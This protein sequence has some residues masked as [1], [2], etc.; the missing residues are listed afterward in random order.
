MIS[1]NDTTE[2]KN[3]DKRKNIKA[4]MLIITYMIFG[5]LWLLVSNFLFP[6]LESKHYNM[7]IYRFLE[8]L[9]FLLITAF[10]LYFSVSK[11]ENYLY[12][13][14]N[15]LK[16]SNENLKKAKERLH[17]QIDEINYKE[18][19]LKV[20]EERYRLAT[21]GSKDG[22]WDLD[23]SN[24]ELYLS[25]RFQDLIGIKAN[26]TRRFFHK[27]K[28]YIHEDD[29]DFL[30]E[31]FQDYLEGT[32]ET[33]NVECRLKTK[34]DQYLW[35]SITG[36]GIWDED[37]NP[38][39]MAGSITDITE[40]KHSER[41]IYNLAYYDQITG[42]PSRSF[43]I[44]KLQELI[45]SSSKKEKNFVV[46]FIDLD[47]FKGVNDTLGHDLGDLLMRNLSGHLQE[48]FQGSLCSRFGGDEFIVVKEI[49]TDKDNISEISKNTVNAL[50]KDWKI[51]DH[52]FY[53]S[54]S[55][56]VS[57][58]PIH[59]TTPQ[60]LIKNADLAMYTAKSRG[61]NTYAIYNP[62]MRNDLL[63][64][65]Q[66]EKDI[67]KALDQDDFIIHY[68]PQV[69]VGKGSCIG[70]EALIRWVH[71]EKGNISPIEFIPIAEESGLIVKMGEIII[72][73]AVKQLRYW[74]DNNQKVV[75]VS[76]NLS[77]MQFQQQNLIQYIEEV[78]GKYSI[79]PSLIKLEI[80][81]STALKDINQTINT[82]KILNSMGIMVALDDFGTGYS[83]LTYLKQLPIS[84]LKIDKSFIKD[85]NSDIREASIV[86]SIITLAHDLSIKVIA[87]GV[88]SVEQYLILKDY[89][90]DEVQGYYFGKPMDEKMFE[91]Y[92]SSEKVLH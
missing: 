76:I 5:I 79:H 3:K 67:I 10:A 7:E 19:A 50:A 88:E 8:S 64:K 23:L 86:L 13:S 51:G 34:N 24:K 84:Y 41:K 78:L 63:E 42:L 43:L 52:E 71:P 56:G 9:I 38:I 21:D 92:I 72:E 68:Q 36:K 65:F 48:L 90:C 59:G 6:F 75:P 14:I 80:T 33:F 22:I 69:S 45:L 66:W 26:N 11:L 57:I 31:N 83:S 54:I 1:Y 39:R 46:F 37:E 58:F 17:R 47:N 73:K 20:S 82:I 44:D 29:L 81:E 18:D 49:D 30:L 32:I 53:I 27:W 55:L 25:S 85:I 35:I 87:E 16:H 4:L 12:L 89:G 62:L 77:P 74:K 61:K 28:S 91:K 70:S 40:R 2:H 15:R 60:D